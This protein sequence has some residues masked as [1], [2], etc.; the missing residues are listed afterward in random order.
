MRR[1]MAPGCVGCWFRQL[2]V[3]AEDLRCN[4]PCFHT[5]S[6]CFRRQYIGVFIF[7]IHVISC[8]AERQ[9]ILAFRGVPR[10][11]FDGGRRGRG[12]SQQQWS[13]VMLS[14]VDFDAS[15]V[16]NNNSQAVFW[17][18]SDYSVSRT[19][20]YNKALAAVRLEA[21]HKRPSAGRHRIR[22]KLMVR[23]ALVYCIVIRSHGGREID[24]LRG[25]F[26]APYTL[27]SLSFGNE[28]CPVI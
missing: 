3:R 5:Q 28:K 25:T 24:D 21:W 14:Q 27:T 18:Q 23:S 7:R 2:N 1:M 9:I 11:W 6:L 20:F 4:I 22:V 16:S 10:P 17:E 12:S 15:C 13:V 8:Y 26:T 19:S